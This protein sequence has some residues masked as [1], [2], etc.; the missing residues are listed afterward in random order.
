L[1]VAI[2]NIDKFKLRNRTDKHERHY[3]CTINS[4]LMKSA[5]TVSTQEKNVKKN[6]TPEL[7][8]VKREGMNNNTRNR[9]P[10]PH[11]LLDF[12]I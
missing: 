2:V 8:I 3:I 12:Q 6:S 7:I 9:L 4:E 11:K 5:D 10:V 1:P